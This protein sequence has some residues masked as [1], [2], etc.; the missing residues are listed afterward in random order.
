MRDRRRRNAGPGRRDRAC[1]ERSAHHSPRGLSP[2]ISDPALRFYRRPGKSCRDVPASGPRRIY[3]GMHRKRLVSTRRVQFRAHRQERRPRQHR[4]SQRRRGFFRHALARRVGRALP[5]RRPR[6]SCDPPRGPQ[7]LHCCG[8]ANRGARFRTSV[9][10]RCRAA[11]RAQRR[12]RWGLAQQTLLCT[13]A[14]QRDACAR[15]ARQPQR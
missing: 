14:A 7:S 11:A 8:N 2:A 10:H 1:G 12:S 13:G 4:D 5:A 3:L 15:P 9:G 6:L